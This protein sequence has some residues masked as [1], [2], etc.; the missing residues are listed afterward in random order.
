MVLWLLFSS[1][2]SPSNVSPEDGHTTRRGNEITYESVITL[3]SLSLLL[4]PSCL[5][6]SFSTTTALFVMNRSPMRWSHSILRHSCLEIEGEIP[7]IHAIPFSLDSLCMQFDSIGD[8]TRECVSWKKDILLKGIRDQMSRKK[9]NGM[10]IL[11]F[12]DALLFI[13]FK[14]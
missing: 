1:L 12:S 7:V 6:L 4:F 2:L 5:V 14:H 9:Q 10:M 8:E 3:H 11:L 13:R